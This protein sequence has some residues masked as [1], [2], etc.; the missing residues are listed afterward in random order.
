MVNHIHLHTFLMY[1][2]NHNMALIIFH[3]FINRLLIIESLKL[4]QAYILDLPILLTQNSYLNYSIS[5]LMP[6]I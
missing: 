1:Q 3:V 6:L 2:A 4:D 5:I